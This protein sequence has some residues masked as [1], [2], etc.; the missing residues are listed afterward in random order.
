MDWWHYPVLILYALSLLAILAYTLMQ[1]HL[2]LIYRRSRRHPESPL[3]AAK[4][5]P[6]VTIQLPVFN[7]KYV[8]RR[9]IRRVA[10]VDWPRD[11]LEIQLLDDSTDETTSLAAREIEILCKEGLDIQHIRRPGRKGFKAGALAYGLERASGEFVAVFDA[12]FLPPPD[13]LQKTIP[14]FEHAETGLVQARWEH[15]NEDA[16]LLTRMQAYALNVHFTIEQKG[17]NAGGFPM[18]FNGT[19]GVWRKSCIEDAGGWHDDTLTEDLDLSYRAQLRGWK[20]RYLDELAA[21]AELPPS[22][23]ALKTQQYRWTKG[24]AETSKKHLFRVWSGNWT[25][26]SKVHATSHLL[27]GSVFLSILL[28]A[29]LSIPLVE[30]KAL[31]PDLSGW[32]W[33]FSVCSLAILAWL[34]IYTTANHRFGSSIRQSLLRF[35]LFLSYSMALS[36]HNSLAV[37]SGWVGKR[38][39]FIRTPKFSDG[40]GTKW[41]KNGYLK[42][43]IGWLPFTEALLAVYFLSGILLAV[44]HSDYGMLPFHLMLAF[45]FGSLSF[46]SFREFMMLNQKQSYAPA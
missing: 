15:L 30:I 38:S 19:A 21:P 18:N 39:D 8:I 13:F 41:L 4:H 27:S 43:E 46:H 3:P 2:L 5:F 37:L 31:R 26:K 11:R 32:F 7:E 24:A 9:L 14:A 17:R 40:A 35:P 28:L 33:F 29:V 44:K 6:K 16:S 25:L 1:S 20:F 34:G 12:D 36:L 22:V 10:E 42:P 45:G 23:Q